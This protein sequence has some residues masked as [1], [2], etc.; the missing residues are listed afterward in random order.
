MNLNSW[1]RF[2]LLP[3]NHLFFCVDLD[4]SLVVLV[5]RDF[6][7]INVLLLLLSSIAAFQS[8]RRFLVLSVIFH[9]PWMWIFIL[10]CYLCGFWTNIWTEYILQKYWGVCMQYEQYLLYLCI[11]RWKSSSDQWIS[12]YFCMW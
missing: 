8:I 10:I 5:K 2:C 7:S 1:A 12:S 11:Q 4:L 3:H 6:R 9:K